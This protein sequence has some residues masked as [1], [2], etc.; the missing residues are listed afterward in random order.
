MNDNPFQGTGEWL[1]ART[2]CLTASRMADVLAVSKRDGKPLKARSDYMKEL[3]AERLTG[4]AMAHVVT[5]AMKDGI[6]REPL[7]RSAYEIAS[8]QIV[9]LCGFVPHPTIE[10]AG[11]SPDGYVGTDGLMEAKCPTVSKHLD[12]MLCKE[13]P[14]EHKPQM[15]WQLACTRRTWCDFV[16]YHPEFPEAKQ[17]FVVRFEPDAA[18]IAAV[19]IEARKFLA[20]VDAC[21][22]MVA[23]AA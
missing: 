3:V 19:E 15:L 8:G 22:Q 11:A 1:S 18:E 23:E 4:S 2:G 6:E 14:E 7:A 12:W 16:S 17:L 20:E 13:V 5:P 21:F 10:Y 9:R